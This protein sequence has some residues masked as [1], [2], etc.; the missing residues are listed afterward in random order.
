MKVGAN[1]RALRMQRLEDRYALDGDSTLITNGHE[2][3]REVG[4]EDPYDA[5]HFHAQAGDY[6]WISV[7]EERA[8]SNTTVRLAVET[9]GGSVFTDWGPTNAMQVFRADETGRYNF[10]ISEYG[11]EQ[12]FD[13]K[14]RFLIQPEPLA[15]TYSHDA[16]LGAGERHSAGLAIGQ[17]SVVQF[18]AVA[19]TSVFAT[20]GERNTIAEPQIWIIDPNGE[21]VASTWANV[22]LTREFQPDFT[23]TYTAIIGDLDGDEPLDFTFSLASLP[24]EVDYD[25]P[26]NAYLQSGERHT[27]AIGVGEQHLVQFDA[28]A[29]DRV[30]ASLGE[31][32]AS[33]SEPQVRIVDPSG[34]AVPGA[35]TWN[36][37]GLQVSFDAPQTGL[38]TAVITDLDGDEPIEYTFSLAVL[39]GAVDYTL[40]QN[41]FV[42]SG[43]RHTGS[44]AIGEQHL[45]Q[46]EATAGGRVYASLGEQAPELSEAQFRVIDP[47]GNFVV[48]SW[49][50]NGLRLEFDAPQTGLYTAVVTDLGVDEPL[51]YTFTVAALP[52]AVDYALP[53]NAF[54]ES[55]QRHTGSIAIGQQHHLQFEADFNAFVFLTLGE[56][57]STGSEVEI[58]VIDPSG[59]PVAG[60]STWGNTGLELAFTAGQAGLYTAVVTEYQSDEALDYTFRMAAF[61]PNGAGA[62]LFESTLTPGG[63]LSGALNFG[64]FAVHPFYVTPAAAAELT[65]TD[66]SGTNAGVRLQVFDQTGRRVWN[67]TDSTTEVATISTLSAGRFFAV[68]SET[69]VDQAITYELS[70]TGIALPPPTV[71]GDYNG[72][73]TVDENDLPMLRASY[74]A[75]GVGLAADGNGDGV[76]NAIDYAIWRENY[77]AVGTSAASIA[78]EET[79][80]PQ[81]QASVASAPAPWAVGS[82]S[83]VIARHT[84]PAKRG[85]IDEALAQ[86]WADPA[87]LLLLDAEPPF[88]T[89]EV[90]SPNQKP[91]EYD[92]AAATDQAYAE[93]GG[94]GGW[95]AW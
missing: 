90:E 57:A 80:E 42:E 50:N 21:L 35:A 89:A 5:F 72:D 11:N 71:R 91:P 36:N 73:Q 92:P 20:L 75:T 88:P 14:V 9:P 15:Y 49:N 64:G 26:Q 74:G 27:G 87:A 82:G 55:G 19:G 78:P 63:T 22:A 94:D 6:V 59:N 3:R 53:Q 51:D 16:V 38:Y 37:A 81:T 45:L 33:N 2:V 84:G 61:S 79:S 25:L 32:V 28:R 60:T 46:F 23:G 52:G 67:G 44:I 54:V 85:V 65:L 10:F 18:E 34:V 47:S 29:G 68:V 58:R 8:K 93:L 70:A 7:G 39:P 95:A 12:D 69:G 4:Q 13:Y 24:G 17:L 77:G 62:S 1:P 76:V 43:Q 83:H 48:G 40:P 66:T 30:Y 41:A 31:V 86:S 56:I